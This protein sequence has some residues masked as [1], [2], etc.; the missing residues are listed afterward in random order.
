MSP[1]IRSS[2]LYAVRTFL[3]AF[4]TKNPI[5]HPIAIRIIAPISLGRNMAN[6]FTKDCRIVIGSAMV[7]HLKQVIVMYL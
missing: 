6:E 2:I 1:V 3:I 5:I 4:P 7:F